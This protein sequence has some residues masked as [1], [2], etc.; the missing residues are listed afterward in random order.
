MERLEKSRTSRR[1]TRRRGPAGQRRQEAEVSCRPFEATG[2]RRDSRDGWVERE[3]AECELASATLPPVEPPAPAPRPAPLGNAAEGNLGLQPCS[4]VAIHHPSPK[5]STSRC[6]PL[7][8]ALVLLPPPSSHLGSPPQIAQ[9]TCLYN[10]DKR[11]VDCLPF[12]R[13]FM[14][15]GRQWTE[16]TPTVNAGG[17][18]PR[19]GLLGVPAD[20]EAAQC[21][22]LSLSLDCR[23]AARVAD[24]FAPLVGL[25]RSRARL[26][27]A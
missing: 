11:A 19:G 13:T 2:E 21:V 26:L 12:V 1:A 7:A 17:R 16:V 18:L 10:A 15:V 9:Y 27:P 3:R 25:C 22:P 20:V 8:L 24:R 23:L 14:Q 6:A 5:P 4:V